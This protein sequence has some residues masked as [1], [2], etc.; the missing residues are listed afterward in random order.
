[1]K[2]SFFAL[3]FFLAFFSGYSQE[4]S[5]EMRLARAESYGG[6]YVF[7][8][9]Y[10]LGEYEVIGE[11]YFNGKS[12][13]NA[14]LMPMPTG[15]SMMLVSGSNPQ[16]TS[17]RNGLVAQALMANREVEGIIVKTPREGEGSATMIKF[18]PN[19][20]DKSLAKVNV[21][22]GILVFSDCVPVAD[23]QGIGRVKVVVGSSS[24]Y[25]YLRDKLSKKASQKKKQ[26]GVQGVIVHL[27][28][29]GIDFAEMIVFFR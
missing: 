6:V 3:A 10:P 27:V 7:N 24:N 19:V 2:K 8:D 18:K 11:V 14:Y 17:I 12:S 25:P 1:M 13:T 15:G 21:H 22:F 23:Y 16:Y 28:E 20:H 4:F 9:S 29:Q 5:Q 26:K